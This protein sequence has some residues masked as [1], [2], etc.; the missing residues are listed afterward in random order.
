[1]NGNGWTSAKQTLTEQIGEVLAE[2]AR[3]LPNKIKATWLAHQVGR[4]WGDIGSGLRRY[5][6]FGAMLHARGWEYQPS[7]GSTGATFVRV[8]TLPD[9]DWGALADKLVAALD[10]ANPPHTDDELSEAVGFRWQHVG[11]TL[12]FFDNVID[13]MARKRGC[14]TGTE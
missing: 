11:R 10:G 8:F 13:A 7:R 9:F 3:P 4:E 2:T 12:L 5:K 6:P 1:V 14:G